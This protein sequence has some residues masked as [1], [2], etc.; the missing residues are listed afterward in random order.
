VGARI[1][2]TLRATIERLQSMDVLAAEDGELS[3]VASEET[4]VE[5]IVDGLR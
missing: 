1:D 4:S 2:R 5:A 3:L